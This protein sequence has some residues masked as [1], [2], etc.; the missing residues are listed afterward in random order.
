LTS[1]AGVGASFQEESPN[2]NLRLDFTSILAIMNLHIPFYSREAKMRTT[3]LRRRGIA[4][5]LCAVILVVA[6]QAGCNLGNKSAQGTEEAPPQEEPMIPEGEIPPDERPPE[7]P[8]PEGEPH[9]IHFFAHQTEIHQGECTAIEW[10][11]E[12]GYGVEINGERVDFGGGMD[13]CPP[14]TTVYHLVV[15]GGDRLVEAEVFIH[16]IGEP[17]G[18]EDH[19]PESSGP[20]EPP[21]PPTQDPAPT[22]PPANP[23]TPPPSNCYTS[24]TNYITDLAITDIYAGNM[25]QGQFWVRITNH[26]PVTCQ[27]VS[28]QFLGCAVV[29]FPTAGGAGIASSAKISV[30]LNIQP[31]ETQNIPTGMGLDTNLNTYAVTCHFAAESGYNDLNNSNQYYQENIP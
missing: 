29:A 3:D 10:L 26:G 31:G 15:D 7:E 1:C 5:I 23:T 14:E 28:F 24:A 9:I 16:V 21:P 11:V 2:S 18:E 30:T 17:S 13:V 8:L 25:P 6:C 27:N 22:A 12:G 20:T 19:P 4:I